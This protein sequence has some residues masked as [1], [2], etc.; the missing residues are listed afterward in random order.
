MTEPNTFQDPQTLTLADEEY[1]A[2]SEGRI[3]I[4][5]GVVA[6]LFMLLVVLV[7][8]AEISLFSD[9][10]HQR[11]LPQAMKIQRA[12]MTDR[13]GELLA[14]TLETYSL[15][16][17]PRRVWNPAETADVLHG[18][19]PHLDRRKLQEK[20]ERDRSFVWLERGLTP[21]E[22]QAV[23]NLGLPGLDFRKEPKRVYP[24]Q[25]LASHIVG[26]TDVDMVGV[27]GAERAFDEQLTVEN[28]PSVALS[29]YVKPV[30]CNTSL[31]TERIL[32]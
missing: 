28:G 14:T 29:M 31:K 5:I 10:A 7:R 15:Y 2:V 16:A 12:D 4:R 19:R 8:L 26:F 22:R 21:K 23:F 20:L 30:S 3:R 6:F 13:H 18:L 11:I 24:R 25:T 27:A 9:G 17:E 32:P 1:R